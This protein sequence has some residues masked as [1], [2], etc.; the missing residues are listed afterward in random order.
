VNPSVDSLS[1][2][3]TATW[4]LVRH[5]FLRVHDVRVSGIEW[6]DLGEL[7][8]PWE[9]L[10]IDMLASHRASSIPCFA[11]D[12]RGDQSVRSV[13]RRRVDASP[14]ALRPSPVGS[15]GHNQGKPPEHEDFVGGAPHRS[16]GSPARS[17]FSLGGPGTPLLEG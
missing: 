2:D 10:P 15:E 11:T 5:Q 7:P 3:S 6:E 4:G 12:K 13:A 17:G 9:L 16:S 14:A 1:L 8:L